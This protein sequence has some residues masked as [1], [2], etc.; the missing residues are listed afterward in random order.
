M[1]VQRPDVDVGAPGVPGDQLGPGGEAGARAEPVGDRVAGGGVTVAEHVPVRQQQPEIGQR[2][3]QRGHLPVEHRPHRHRVDGGQEV[4]EPEVAVHDPSRVRPLGHGGGERVAQLV[5]ARQRAAAGLVELRGPAA[6]LPAEEAV[7]AAEVGQPDRRGV[8][9]VQGGERVHH[10]Q[11]QLAALPGGQRVGL[12]PAAEHLAG[13]PLHEVE[14]GADH[15]GVG[16]VQQRRGHRHGG[17]GQG[18][19]DPVLPGHVVRGGQHVPERG[20]AQHHLVIAGAQQVR[21]VRLASG[22]QPG[23]QRRGGQLRAAPGQVRGE[24][25]EVQPPWGRLLRA[26]RGRPVRLDGRIAHPN[27]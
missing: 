19:D 2:I 11:G 7:G 27:S 23:P 14:R 3:A 22:D 18:R 17:G 20:A 25:V 21:Q 13:H 1:P 8:D 26:G 5:D 6:D 12:R 24:P 9:R 15:V 10:G 16:A 4:V